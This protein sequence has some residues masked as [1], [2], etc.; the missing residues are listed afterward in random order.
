[1]RTKKLVIA[2]LYCI[3]TTNYAQ[4]TDLCTPSGY[5]VGFFNGVWNTKL[6]ALDGA[7]SLRNSLLSTYKNEPL[8]YEVFYN[9]TTGFLGL[10]DVA[11]VFEQRAAELDGALAGRWE[12]FWEVLSSTSNQTSF[13]Q[14]LT[15]KIGSASS[16]ALNLLSSLYT[17]I[18]TKSVA[19]WSYLLS[20]PPTDAD[21][22]IQESRIKELITQRKKIL[23]LGH[24]QGNLFLNR[25]YD[26]GL[27]LTD[28]NSIKA[29]HIAPASPTLRGEHSL[30]D[31]DLIINGLRAQ[32]W[33][34]VP[35]VTVSIPASHLI[36]DDFSGHTLKDTYLNPR[37]DTLPQVMALTQT[38]LDSLVPPATHGNNGFFTVILTWD[39]SGDVDLHAFEPSSTHVYY[40][41]KQGISGY[42]DVD[43]TS[44]NGPEHY[45]ASCDSTKLATGTY[46][47]GINNYARA[48]GRIATVQVATNGSGEI[49]TKQ[50]GVG[51]ELGSRGNSSPIPVVSV[52]V[53]KDNN[54]KYTV[55]AT[56]R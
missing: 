39:G 21:L 19:G 48:T 43:N 2:C 34:T 50:L 32:G 3:L 36:T 11:E 1:V 55:S 8:E 6:Q 52:N 14:K 53:N 23:L 38:A 10:G 25:V 35:S 7:S 18:I 17:D 40:A 51:A 16:E 22:A 45:F 26:A 24:S 13:I 29:V 30:A 27:T 54:G 33:L 9:Q 47:I 31:L 5:V 12:I 37:R 28:T 15:S 41:N 44:A 42:L 56:A 49:F 46:Q 20:N 4:A